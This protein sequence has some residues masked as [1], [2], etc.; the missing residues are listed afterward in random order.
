MGAC[1]AGWGGPAARCP[2]PRWGLGGAQPAPPMLQ[3]G[4]GCPP[5]PVRAGCPQQTQL[6]GGLLGAPSLWA[7]SAGSLPVPQ[8]VL[9][10]RRAAP[11]AGA[12]LSVPGPSS[13]GPG[14][15]GRLREA[16]AE[17]GAAALPQH[18][19]WSHFYSAGTQ[20]RGTAVFPAPAVSH[21]PS[22]E[23]LVGHP[24]PR[25]PEH[26]STLLP[27]PPIACRRTESECYE[28]PETALEE[29]RSP[30]NAST[31]C[32][33]APCFSTSRAHTGERCYSCPGQGQSALV[34]RWPAETCASVLVLAGV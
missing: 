17:V 8:P 32:R 14:S 7:A 28:P 4:G 26:P 2:W 33:G 6:G 15:C 23:L 24:P 10:P 19:C 21:L 9:G 13:S 27:R 11:A 25:A 3:P 16:G 30:V 5:R 22:C 20:P 31:C 12:E 18:G 1:G 29:E 34:P